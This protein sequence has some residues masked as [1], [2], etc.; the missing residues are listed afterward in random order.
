MIKTQLKHE[1][2]LLQ[3]P[4]EIRTQGNWFCSLLT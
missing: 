4:W 1:Q 3:K 2:V